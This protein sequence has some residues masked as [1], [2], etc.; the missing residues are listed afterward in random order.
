MQSLANRGRALHPIAVTVLALA[1]CSDPHPGTPTE[2]VLR[3][4]SAT[5][6]T[7]D[8]V[9]SGLTIDQ[10]T[11]GARAGFNIDGQYGTDTC[12]I[13][14][15]LSPLGDRINEYGCSPL[16]PTCRGGV[17]NHLPEL[18]SVFDHLIATSF[19]DRTSHWIANGRAIWILRVTDVDSTD[20][21]DNV[22]VNVY[23]GFAKYASCAT[24][25]SSGASFYVDNAS[26]LTSGDLATPRWTLPGSIYNKRLY[27][28]RAHSFA[29]STSTPL[30]VSVALGAS[31]SVT[32]DMY[33]ASLTASALDL[34]SGNPAP[35][36]IGGWLNTDLFSYALE[37]Q[38][39]SLAEGIYRL[40]PRLSD[41]PNPSTNA[42]D[43]GTPLAV[44]GISIGAHVTLLPINI[45]GTQ[46]SPDSGV[47]GTSW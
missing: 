17:D 33:S 26:L 40:M 22:V 9:L 28:T 44:G 4:V 42:C 25:F 1:G 45:L 37:L 24:A 19:R 47:C 5:T 11:D 39:T 10:P 23:R 16:L 6:S 29:G 30:P 31:T 21:D 12:G 13:P 18:A 27:V 34:A 38:F 14:D 8:F 15:H 3:R 32:F 41:L 7:Y 36:M 2:P 20:E 43:T 35:A 46:S